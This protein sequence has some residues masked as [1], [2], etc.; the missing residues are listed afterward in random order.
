MQVKLT[1]FQA[2]KII[3]KMKNNKIL[4]IPNIKD[5]NRK[6]INLCTQ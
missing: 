5:N 4:K 2:K 3:I 1:N 6:Q